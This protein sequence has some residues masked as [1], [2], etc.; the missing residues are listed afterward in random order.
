LEMKSQQFDLV[1]EMVKTTITY[2]TINVIL[3]SA[4]IN[5]PKLAHIDGYKLATN[6]EIFTEIKLYLA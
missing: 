3:I 4:K 2:R 6:W 5:R 1:L